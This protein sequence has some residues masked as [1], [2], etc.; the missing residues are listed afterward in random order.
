M[1][2][3][4]EY[5]M[6]SIERVYGGKI[7]LVLSALL[8]PPSRL[9][10]RV[11]TLR[12]S[13]EEVIE[14]IRDEGYDVYRDERLHEALYFKVEGPNTIKDHGFRVLV[15]KKASESIMMGANVYSPGV[16]ECDS[17]IKAG[18]IA[19]IYSENM[20]PIAEG[21][22]VISCE[23]ARRSGKGL[24]LR[25]IKSLYRAPPVRE[26]KA[27]NKG[28]IYPQSLPSMVTSRI[29]DPRPGEVIVDMCAAP[30]GKTGHIYELSRGRSFIYAFDHSKKRVGEMISNLSRLG[31]I[32][33]NN[34]TIEI[35]DSR[36]L[37][38]DYPNLV[39][40]KI[41]LDP[42][43][44]STGVRPKIYD[45]KK[46]KDLRNLVEYQSQFLSEAYRILRRGGILVYS[47]CSITYDENEGLLKRFIDKK[48]FKEVDPPE[49]AMN[50]STPGVDDIGIRFDP[51]RDDSQG[52][53]IGVLMK[54]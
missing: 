19:T 7:D 43:C 22:A 41:L 51:Y 49:W 15:D 2:R 47:T 14:M 4:D 36:Y 8:R 24:F 16:L 39:A 34:L 13:V 38:I 29:L 33:S 35:A 21:E 26:L 46:E 6:R 44:T 40:D 50:I 52:Y 11:N 53:F 45:M 10:V 42:P 30:G 5:V 31:H 12:A 17:M 1:I 28:L 32:P 3:Y 25:N 23:E 9:Y 37:S 27:W 48:M 20:I 18:T 54:I